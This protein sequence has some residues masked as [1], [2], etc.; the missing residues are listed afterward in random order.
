MTHGHPR[1]VV[2]P[3][4]FLNTELLHQAIAAHFKPASASL[5]SRL[6]ND[7]SGSVEI[8]RFESGYFAAPN[9]MAV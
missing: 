7:D 5:F 1:C 3:I 8:A 9:N 2:H 6:E 4:D